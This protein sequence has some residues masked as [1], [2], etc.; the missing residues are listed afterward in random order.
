MPLAVERSG[1]FGNQ[2]ASSCHAGV[3]FLPGFERRRTI[4]LGVA[5][6]ENHIA[7]SRLFY[8]FRKVLDVKVVNG[9][10]MACGFRP[11]RRSVRSN[12]TSARNRLWPA[13]PC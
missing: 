4:G 13:T 2:V 3:V 8:H 1:D 7:R 6:R 11:C 12:E 9:P 10:R 5:N